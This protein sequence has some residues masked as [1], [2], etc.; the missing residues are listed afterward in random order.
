MQSVAPQAP[1]VLLVFLR[2]IS[3]C[4]FQGKM[5]HK[6]G[7]KVQL[8]FSR[9]IFFNSRSNRSGMELYYLYAEQWLLSKEINF[10]WK[11]TEAILLKHLVY[12]SHA[13]GKLNSLV[14]KPKRD[15]TQDFQQYL[16]QSCRVALIIP[17]ML[18]LQ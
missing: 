11:C 18:D 14:T 12:S 5:A 3:L 9:E 8:L 10:C 16:R 4:Y 7:N 17:V 15:D 1:P 6:L 2:A 13:T